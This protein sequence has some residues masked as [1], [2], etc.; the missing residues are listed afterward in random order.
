LKPFSDIQ[1]KRDQDPEHPFIGADLTTVD[2]VLQAA[3][4]KCTKMFSQVRG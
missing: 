2:T 1:E 3:F 4:G